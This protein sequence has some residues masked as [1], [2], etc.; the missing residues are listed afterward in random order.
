MST[1]EITRPVLILGAG[2]NGCCV[3]RELV[4]NGIP[5]VLVDEVDIAT[6][7]TAKASRLIH[8]GVRYLEYGDFKLVAESLHERERLLKLAPQ[9]VRPLKLHIPV[10]K[11]FGGFVQAGFRF[12]RMSQYSFGRWMANRLPVHSE[13]GLMV[14]RMGLWLY[15]F[16]ARSS[17]LPSHSLQ[18]VGEAGTPEVDPEKFHW[19]CSY[20]DAQMIYPERFVLALLEDARRHAA[21]HNIEFHVYTHHG[22]VF[23][24]NEA[25]IR[26]VADGSPVQT[27]VPSSIVNATGAWGD[28]TLDDM[29]VESERLLGGTKGSHFITSHVGLRQCLG[30]SGIYAE[31]ADGRL[32]FI[33]PFGESVLV[34]TTDER[35]TGPPGEAIASEEELD[36]LLNMTNEV[37]PGT[38]L[39][40]A[41]IGMH[42]CGVRP[43]PYMPKGRTGSIPRG[44]WIHTT[45][46]QRT[47]VDTL[48][49]GKLTTCREFG[50]EVADLIMGRLGVSRTNGTRERLVPGAKDFPEDVDVWCQQIAEETGYST[51]QVKAVFN[52]QGT[53]CRDVLKGND[54][55]SDRESL[56][57]TNIPI[58]FVDWV[59]QHEWVGSLGDMIERR[60][61]LVL[62][63]VLLEEAISVV[64]DRLMT[65]GIL[66]ES[67]RESDLKECLTR[68][69]RHYGIEVSASATTTFST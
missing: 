16:I 69:R 67:N 46:R 27:F 15:D 9:F 47:P 20:Y 21:E 51:A 57:G 52:L 17:L 36:Y 59:I 8:G 35:F 56:P 7:A 61:G 40:R 4:L 23:E 29:D 28:L 2:I 22:A 39:T 60:L 3:A 25:T 42:Y 32:V 44:H 37:I 68:L 34:G 41:D 43:L 24:E 48:I 13:R 50:E 33:L 14:V 66:S 65:A 5:V 38:E 26:S 11:R 30:D 6:G 62:R 63:P 55:S 64:Q 45:D 54:S 1:A 49:G 31:A 53:A 12:L 10:S 18:R 58:S 19:L